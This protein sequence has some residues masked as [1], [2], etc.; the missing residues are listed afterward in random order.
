MHPHCFCRPQLPAW[1]GDSDLL[2]AAFGSFVGFG[3]AWILLQYQ[4]RA[5]AKK[6]R[7]RRAEEMESYVV[8]SRNLL[9]RAVRGWK[10]T[11]QRFGDLGKAYMNEPYSDHPHSISVNV[12]LRTLERMD[13]ILL[14]DSY[15]HVWGKR[16]GQAMCSRLEGLI[17]FHGHFTPVFE[18]GVIAIKSEIESSKKQF[19]KLQLELCLIMQNQLVQMAQMGRG[20]DPLATALNHI[21]QDVENVSRTIGTAASPLT[22]HTTL[23]NPTVRLG[24]Q[25]F[26][27]AE[28]API[29]S[30][31]MR[32]DK[33][34]KKIALR[35]IEIDKFTK[36]QGAAMDKW[37]RRADDLLK[38]LDDQWA[39]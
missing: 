38:R 13:R 22:I 23:V 39:S 30:A 18:T 26:R 11:R 6:E 29:W 3:L 8:H 32:V 4:F 27:P 10:Q 12:A 16:L 14:R 17:D 20:N 5:E 28:F 1:L 31:A 35:A 24:G 9:R 7:L 19:D 21:L 2:G 33:E 15:T 34:Y 37:N 36:T 25:G